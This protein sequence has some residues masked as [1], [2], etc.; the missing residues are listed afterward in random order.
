MFVAEESGLTSSH[1]GTQAAN[2]CSRRQLCQ[3]QVLA[4]WQLLLQQLVAQGAGQD[5]DL[6]GAR[7]R[8]QTV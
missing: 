2:P 8:P 6:L 5:Q 1:G 3:T 7:T 4:N